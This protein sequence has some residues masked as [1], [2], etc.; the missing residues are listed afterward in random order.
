MQSTKSSSKNVMEQSVKKPLKSAPKVT[1]KEEK[2]TKDDETNQ[3][4]TRTVVSRYILTINSQQTLEK[5]GANGKKQFETRCLNLLKLFPD[6]VMVTPGYPDNLDSAEFNFNYAFEEGEKMHRWHMHSVIEIKHS[7]HI[8]IDFFSL[9][10]TVKKYGY[11][12]DCRFGHNAKVADNML[13]YVRKNN[14]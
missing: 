6:L 2:K 4:N 1:I 9:T 8:K 13:K 12:V 3:G 7:T 14:K 5:L 10:E 11:H